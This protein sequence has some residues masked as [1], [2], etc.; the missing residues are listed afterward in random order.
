MRRQRKAKILATLGPASS[1]KEMIRE[2]FR[3]GADV[4]RLNFSHGSH[5]DHRERYEAIREIE[6]E[7]ERPIGIL[8]DLQGP[9]LRVGKLEGGEVTLKAGQAFRLDLDETPGDTKRAPLL[10]PEIFAAISNGTSLLIDDGKL[11]L[12][13]QDCTPDYA[14]TRV[15]TGGA[16]RDHKGVNLPGVILPIS[17]ITEKDRV[18]L[19]FALDLGVDWIALSFIQ[20]PEDLTEARRLV[21][22]RAA[23]MTKVE[24]P[25]ALD[26]LAQLIALSDAV[27]VARGDLGVEM[28]P[29]AIPSRQKQIIHACRLS[30]IPVVVATQMLESMISA[31]APTRAEASDVATAVYDGADAVMLSAESAA[32]K[33]PR[34][35]V[36][37]MDRI[38]R[39][40]EADPAYR[41]ILH[42]RDGA[43]EATGADAISAAASQV[44]A[45]L[46]TAAIVT[47]TMSG[48]TALRA[49]RQRPNA[50][51]MVLTNELRTARRLAGLWGA[52][53]VLTEDVSNTQE[54]VE[55]ACRL[56]VR[57]GMANLGDTLVITAG[58]PF[59]TQG[60]TNML[61]IARVD[62]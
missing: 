36:T 19:E 3:A 51:I 37:F 22:D 11:R 12:E 30:G 9:K 57:E 58:V 4:F 20:R 2:L 21:G 24:K 13:V 42:A 1:S 34:E 6:A 45:T 52:H 29:E 10:H 39:S 40:T 62:Y 16:L 59:K 56:A 14:E 15:V 61:R 31:P 25:A 53:C 5:D 32:G 54:M 38:I 48:S 46:E 55:K 26:C 8:A 28:P 44:A 33:Y 47:Y 60:T 43:P 49:A 23:I 7:L 35:A 27:M 18:D 50:P 17:P 41:G